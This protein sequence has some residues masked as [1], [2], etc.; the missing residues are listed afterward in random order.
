MHPH[1]IGKE[2]DCPPKR[3]SY[4]CAFDGDRRRRVKFL[5]N[6]TLTKPSSSITF[7]ALVS[8]FNRSVESYPAKPLRGPGGPLPFSF[9]L[10]RFSQYHHQT[11]NNEGD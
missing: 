8:A 7:S 4:H 1:A 3:F 10:T 9:A 11:G 2:T 5:G 6:L